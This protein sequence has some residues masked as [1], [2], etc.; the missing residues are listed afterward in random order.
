M[1][2]FVQSAP[3]DLNWTTSLEELEELL[4]S[5]RESALGPDGL[6]YIVYRSAGEIGAKLLLAA[7]QATLQGAALPV[8]K[9]HSQVERDQRAEASHSLT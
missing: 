9:F 2:S 6:P 5:K 3:R 1:L 7:W 4:A 8:V